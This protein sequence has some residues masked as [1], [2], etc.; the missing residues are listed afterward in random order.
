MPRDEFYD[1]YLECLR[2]HASAHQDLLTARDDAEQQ[3]QTRRLELERA[4]QAEARAAR[5]RRERPYQRL[6]VS[7]YQLLCKGIGVPVPQEVE[8]F[9]KAAKAAPDLAFTK[10]IDDQLKAVHEQLYTELTSRWHR[11]MERRAYFQVP[12]DADD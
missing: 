3:A 4:R 5:S 12:P 10:E 6:V 9:A 1:A 11:S 8:V 7:G 2:N